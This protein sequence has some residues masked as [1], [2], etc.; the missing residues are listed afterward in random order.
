MVNWGL[1]KLAETHKPPSLHEDRRDSMNLAID[2]NDLEIEVRE[3]HKPRVSLT[4][5]RG[6]SASGGS[7]TWGF[8]SPHDGCISPCR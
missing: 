6:G 7:Q 8:P 5:R 2:P 3:A 4:S 1:A